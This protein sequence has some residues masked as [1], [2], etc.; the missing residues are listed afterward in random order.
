MGRL[1]SKNKIFSYV[2]HI[3]ELLI[4]WILFSVLFLQF[5]SRYLLNDSPG[6]TEEISRYLL[7]GLAFIGSI[8]CVKRNAH[9]FLEFIYR[10]VSKKTTKILLIIVGLTST[11]FYTFC[12]YLSIILINKLSNQM[13]VTINYPKNILYYF[14]FICLIIMSILSF[15]RLIKMVKIGQNNSKEILNSL[16]SKGE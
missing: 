4:F 9:I 3:P 8:T 16:S 12:T 10:M 7:I 15:I 13:M 6:W 2:V 11:F 5:F 14:I 1:D